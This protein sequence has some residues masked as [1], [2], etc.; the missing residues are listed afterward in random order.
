M[1]KTSTKRYSL[2]Q[3]HYLWIEWGNENDIMFQKMFRIFKLKGSF[4]SWLEL[5]ELKRR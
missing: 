3:L 5:K 2:R 1:T 4:T